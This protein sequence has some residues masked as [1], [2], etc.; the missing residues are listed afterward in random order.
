MIDSSFIK[1]GF[2][3]FR[4]QADTLHFKLANG[5]HTLIDDNCS[6]HYHVYAPGRYI[7]ESGSGCRRVSDA[8]IHDC[9]RS[10][11]ISDRFA[12][13]TYFSARNWAKCF[14][15]YAMNGVSSVNWI[16]LPMQPSA[17]T[18]GAWSVIIE[19]PSGLQCAFYNC[20]FTKND[21]VQS[22]SI[23]IPGRYTIRSGQAFYEG[24][25]ALDLTSQYS[26]EHN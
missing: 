12:H 4:I 24:P 22:Y 26:R 23:Q 25:S 18:Q 7:V 5:S 11:R 13:I 6:A 21:D 3:V 17:T 14:V 2:R 19:A 16:F 20:P 15:G 9:L 10:L 8:Q 1:E